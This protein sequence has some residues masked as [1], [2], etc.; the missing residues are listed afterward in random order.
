MGSFDLA[1]TPD[2]AEVYLN[3]QAVGTTPLKL[4]KVPAGIVHTLRLRRS[5]FYDHTVLADVE[6][7][8]E[9]RLH[10]RMAPA[11]GERAMATVLVET[12]PIGA[13]VG[14]VED[15]AEKAQGRTTARDGVLVNARIDHPLHLRATLDRH[16]PAVADLDV[17]DPAYTLYL[18]LAPPVV[19][20]GTLSV[21]GT[22]GLTVYVGPEEVGTVPFKDVRLKAGDHEMVIVDNKTGKRFEGRLTIEKDKNATRKATSDEAQV[23]VE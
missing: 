6:A 21:S 12:N 9:S 3:G 4:E 14:V 7:D 1:S 5:G 13:T 11:V 15:A 18:R 10:V 19:H 23:R 2:A 20:Y 16:S 8:K 22:K 17:K